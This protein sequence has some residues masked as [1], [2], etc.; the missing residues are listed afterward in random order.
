MFKFKWMLLLGLCLASSCPAKTHVVSLSKSRQGQQPTAQQSHP[1]SP[2]IYG[3][4][5]YLHE[6]RA[7]EWLWELKPT[8]YRWGGNTS[9]RYNYLTNAWNTGAD[10]YFHNYSGGT[11]NII[12][13]FMAE[14]LEH[15]AAS[16]ITVP[17]MGW[18]AKDGHSFS[19]PRELFPKQDS[20]DGDA[21]NGH[22]GVEN[23]K[24]DPKTTSIPVTPEFVAG[25]VQK[26]KGQFGRNPH[27]YIMDNEPMLWNSTHR[28][29]HPE[30]MS[31]DGYLK[32]YID[33]ASAVRQA[34]PDAVIVGPALWGWMAMQASA[35]DVEG[36][37][38]NGLRNTDKAAHL[39]KP[40]LEW[41][42]EQLAKEE[43]IRKISLLDVLDVH[44]YPEKSNWPVGP[45][46][47]RNVRRQLLRSTRSLWDRTYTDESWINEKLYF[48]PRLKAMA[49]QFKP[50][51]KVSIGEYNFRSEKDASG[52]I[53]QADIL[54][55]M[56]R[57]DLY[58]AQY[59]TFPI[60]DGT[61]RNAFLL[62]RNFDGKGGSFG[63][64]YLPNSAGNEEDY[65]VYT[66]EDTSNNRLT[67]VILNKSTTEGQDFDLQVASFGKAKSAKI[68][69]WNSTK[70]PAVMER[71][72]KLVSAPQGI[73][74][75]TK[76]LSMQIVE[77]IY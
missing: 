41:F 33:F 60:K 66:A 55:I 51:A 48:I 64:R 21:G 59:W 71:Y 24:A 77:L 63:D 9:S 43:K 46:S 23:L 65:S 16:M 57:E 19:Y 61:H 26:L 49:A 44:F 6:D 8:L 73:T 50:T 68:V 69:G 62:Y 29:V 52:A 3:F 1:I 42:L 25:W 11:P 30:P 2:Y 75:S 13:S 34:D 14:N 58:A 7:K 45:D 5:T 15:S 70:D 22:N 40:F 47:G 39:G 12:D 72:E 18:V 37:W 27:F 4:G 20:F 28:D 38:S 67:I 76:P 31:Y 32:L 54:G 35:F 36:P 10:W 56:G 53:A 17:M 74:V